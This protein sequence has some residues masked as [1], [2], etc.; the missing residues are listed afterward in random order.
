MRFGLPRRIG[1]A[2]RRPEASDFV[3]FPAA[4]V[5]RWRRKTRAWNGAR[6]PYLLELLKFSLASV[7]GTTI[8]IVERT[9]ATLSEKRGFH[10][11]GVVMP[12]SILTEPSPLLERRSSWRRGRA[13][14]EAKPSGRR[15]R[16]HLRSALYR[17]AWNT[18]RVLRPTK[19]FRTA[20]KR[21]LQ[22]ELTEL[23]VFSPDLP[24]A[25]DGYRILHLTDLHLDN[26]LDTAAAVAEQITGIDYHLCVITG[27]IRDNIH[28]PLA[29]LIDRL[30]TI[31][32]ACDGADGIL[33]VLGNHD[34][35]SMVDSMEEIGVKVLVNE[36]HTLMRGRD[37]LHF[38]GLDDVHRFRSQAADAA[39]VSAPDGFCIALVHSPE[40]AASAAA[41]HRLYLTGH[42][43][44]GQICLPS[45]RAFGHGLTA[46]HDYAKGLWC[47]EGM[48][49]YTGRG[50]GT[51]VL[52]FRSHCPGEIAVVTLQQGPT[53]ARC[54]SVRNP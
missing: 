5:T 35:V 52:P 8:F 7:R 48:Y 33:A 31:V 1:H 18:H 43:H 42:T 51:C 37:A 21:A 34:S 4:R 30:N 6:V 25:F 54:V 40:V 3:D 32:G 20:A 39:L 36:H 28:A 29:P 47:H 22:F 24:P 38:T 27:D 50:V 11:P 16:G 2:D 45:G 14:M 46:H 49:G 26:I 23:Q 15:W 53:A 12:D 9:N 13:E 41:R 19:A 17:M 10:R 44:G